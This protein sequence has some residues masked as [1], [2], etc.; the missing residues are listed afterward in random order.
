MST[1]LESGAYWI[2]KFLQALA[3]IRM[4]VHWYFLR[5]DMRGLVQAM[6]VNAGIF[7]LGWLLALP[8]LRR[9]REEEGSGI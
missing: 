8:L 7:V 6:F 9:K 4:L 1:L 3:I 2:G 5:N